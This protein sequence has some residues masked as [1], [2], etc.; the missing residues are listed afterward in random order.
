MTHRH[1][2][3]CIVPSYILK[4]IAENGTSA[5]Q[6]YA[7]HNLAHSVAVRE[8]RATTPTKSTPTAVGEF[9]SLPAKQRTIYSAAEQD[10]L[11][12][13]QVRGEGEPPTGDAAVDEA[14]DGAGATYDLFNQIYDRVSIDGHGLKLDSTVHYRTGYDNA[15]WNGRQMVYGDGDEDL[16]EEQR[17][18]NRFTIAL[19]IIGHELTHG[20]T[21]FSAGLIYENQAGALNESFSDVFGSLVKQWKLGQT[22]VEADWLIGAGLF[23]E[24]VNATGLRSLKAPGTAYND[25][26]LGK[27]PQPAHMDQYVVTEDDHGGVHINSGIPNHAFYLMASEI[28]GFA[29]EKAGRIWYTVLQNKLKTTSTFQNAADA[30]HQVAAD[31]YGV[32]SIEQ[33]AV[34][35]GWT[36]VGI[37]PAPVTLPP[38]PAS[39][40]SGCRP[41]LK[42]LLFLLNG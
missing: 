3:S 7:V 32:D 5:Q 13:Q 39:T 29:W 24:N 27:D 14:Y 12:G 42:S 26:V 4:S 21:Q 25:P 19:D 2:L 17:L 15:F 31:L 34:H 1:P 33:Q 16:P 10:I 18:F 11:P 30:T 36:A 41:S 37:T 40:A 38:P 20:V 23:T 6:R 8:R 35:N 22:A 28:G 9:A